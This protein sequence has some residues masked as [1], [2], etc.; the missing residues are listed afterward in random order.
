MFTDLKSAG[1]YTKMLAFYPIV[2]GVAASHAINANRDTTYDLTFAGGMSHNASGMTTNGSN[3]YGNTN[4]TPQDLGSAGTGL[5]SHHMLASISNNL[6]SGGYEGAGPSPYLIHRLRGREA[7]DG[8]SGFAPGIQYDLVG[9]QIVNRLATNS[10]NFQVQASGGTINKNTST[11][12]STSIS[13]NNI[14]IG[15]ASTT[16]F[17]TNARYNFFSIGDGLTDSEVSDL[18]AAINTFNNS[19]GRRVW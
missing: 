9:I 15:N 3:A 13:T 12:N 10:V 5:D 1:V 2:G 7:Y 19:L 18:F 17:Y 11:T 14:H 4:A 16:G 6:G 8:Q